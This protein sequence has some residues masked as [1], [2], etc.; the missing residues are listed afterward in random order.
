MNSVPQRCTVSTQ[1]SLLPEL[2]H[3]LKAHQTEQPEF[4]VVVLFGRPGSIRLAA[5]LFNQPGLAPVTGP[6]LEIHARRTQSQRDKALAEFHNA[7]R[8]GQF[9]PVNRLSCINW[10]TVIFILWSY[11]VRV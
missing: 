8:R 11:Q 3:I 10:F 9:N 4:K 7:S 6:V 2:A 5:T 1:E